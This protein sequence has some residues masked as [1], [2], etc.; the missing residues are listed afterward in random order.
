M[1]LSTLS[2]THIAEWQPNL[3]LCSMCCR[4]HSEASWLHQVKNC[5]AVFRPSYCKTWGISLSVSVSNMPACLQIYRR[6]TLQYKIWDASK[7]YES[8]KLEILWW[9]QKRAV[10]CINNSEMFPVVPVA[11]SMTVLL[12]G[13]SQNTAASSEWGCIATLEQQRLK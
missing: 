4:P 1:P 3:R 13:R 10:R 6:C 2:F 5:I 8:L 12:R 9:I 11:V 7:Q